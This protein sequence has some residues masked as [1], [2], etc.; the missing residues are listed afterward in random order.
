MKNDQPPSR[1]ADL[2]N[3]LSELTA[4]GLALLDSYQGELAESRLLDRIERAKGEFE[5]GVTGT[6]RRGSPYAFG[7]MRPEVSVR[8]Y[9]LIRELGPAVLVETGVC[10]GVSTA[11]ILAALDRNNAG[12]LYSIDL[13]EFTETDY[14]QD[15]FWEGKKGAVVP[16]GMEP[17]WIIPQELRQRWELSIGPSQVLLPS[18]LEHLKVIDFFLH[19]SEHS[20]ECMSFEYQVAWKHLRPGGVLASDD[21]NWN[22]A[23]E[24]FA[25]QHSRPIYPI[26]RSLAFII[27]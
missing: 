13:P 3:R 11:V 26:E 10:N 23:F 14:A 15:A 12:R 5:L 27:R 7:G 1:S 22:T 21:T 24:D 20:Y 9:G 16:K 25:R 4:R 2:S 19:D 18:V 8:L 17:G 6:T